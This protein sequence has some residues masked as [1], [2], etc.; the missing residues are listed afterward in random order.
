MVSYI[1]IKVNIMYNDIVNRRVLEW[2]LC[3][4]QKSNYSRFH[5]IRN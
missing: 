3:M 1:E 5:Q 2:R 4:E